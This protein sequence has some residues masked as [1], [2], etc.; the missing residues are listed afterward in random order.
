MKGFFVVT[1]S[2]DILPHSDDT[3]DYIQRRKPGTII[4][5]D[6][7]I[8]RNSAFHRKAMALFKAVNDNLPEPEPIEY[9][10]KMI[11]PV[12]N[13]DT[14][15]KYL[16]IMAGY[17]DLEIYPNGKVRA[18]AQSLA[19]D[20]MDAETFEKLYSAVID[21]A[22]RLMGDKWTGAELERVTNEI[23]RFA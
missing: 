4:S 22:L 12:N 1:E 2:K 23:M 18:E 15:R 14:T 11:Q 7:K 16:T 6:M 5:A 10:G 13:F 19:Y 9:K 21:A 3:F 20:N 8:S 17:S